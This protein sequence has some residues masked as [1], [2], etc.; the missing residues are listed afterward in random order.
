M[1][2]RRRKGWCSLLRGGSDTGGDRQLTLAAVLGLVFSF[3]GILVMHVVRG[4]KRR[5]I[6][7][8]TTML[9]ENVGSDK[10]CRGG[11]VG[12]CADII[13]QKEVVEVIYMS[14]DCAGYAGRD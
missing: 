7:L 9:L 3:I 6:N 13:L 5:S 2:G 12:R 14:K 1:V 4:E 10:V 11:R 8:L